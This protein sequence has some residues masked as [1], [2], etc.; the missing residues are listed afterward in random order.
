[1]TA[2]RSSTS[3]FTESALRVIERCS[4]FGSLWNELASGGF[5]S[6][7]SS[8]PAA[9]LILALLEE[10]SLASASLRRL[11]LDLDW[12]RSGGLGPEA[13]AAVHHWEASDAAVHADQAPHGS[14]GQDGSI[15]LTSAHRR[16]HMAEIRTELPPAF[17][18]TLDRALLVARQSGEFEHVSSSHLL[19]A[20]IELCAVAQ[21][22]MR[23]RGVDLRRLRRELGL[24]AAEPTER[25][26]V[27]FQLGEDIPD[28]LVTSHS[29]S[30]SMEPQDLAERPAPLVQQR[31][32]RV[33]D[34]VLNRCREG[35]R[36][37][38]DHARFVL[39]DA[40][41]CRELKYLRHDLVAAEK[42]L[43]SG[44]AFSALTSAG[45]PS[46][47][48]S[49][50]IAHPLS[51]P[52]SPAAE[53]SA[54]IPHGTLTVARDVAGDSGTQLTT[55]G[56]RQRVSIE[57]LVT[58]NFR[59]VQEAF[60]SLEEFGKLLS[61]DFAAA[62]KQFRYRSYELQSR[63]ACGNVTSP[64]ARQTHATEP[65]NAQWQPESPTQAGPA[66][67]GLVATG[68]GAVG[69]DARRHR[70]QQAFVYVLITEDLCSQPWYLVAEEAL[71][72]GADVIQL[73][74][75]ALD[76]SELLQRARRLAELCHRYGA[77]MIVN[78]RP[79]IAML[80]GADG[81]HVGQEEIPL[82][83]VRRLVGPDLLIGISS[84]NPD[85]A[86]QAER[87]G[88]DYLGV[89]PTFPSRTKQFDDFPGL[90][91]VR[92]A[93]NRI[94]IPWFAIGGIGAAEAALLSEAG[95]QRAAVSS[96]VIQAKSPQAAAQEIRASLM[97]SAKSR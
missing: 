76:D 39:N 10:E 90:A 56:E 17:T 23:A 21:E 89:G 29:T 18:A 53:H 24:D 4:R 2:P 57:D 61:P 31:I 88:A 35:I 63:L 52:V 60:R 8:I 73:R 92:E 1:M 64:S 70:L 38:E 67:A 25:L 85:Q 69:G 37:L 83:D 42:R 36:V 16:K 97:K 9:F 19:L 72:G 3:F 43:L 78:D 93:V 48:P 94:R 45:L 66:G 27:D 96:F 30:H 13:T 41:L 81:V 32:Q 11:E 65:H 75:K 71:R 49:G 14:D 95:C 68:P 84:H 28:P 6:M 86:L 80:S 44:H 74:E 5:S 54:A 87:G 12:L 91:F 47:F 15:E 82:D 20:A 62:M 51:A 77:L 58:A 55:D 79:D 7:N 50:P 33:L 40:E 26:T 22:A 59:R 46:G 34:A